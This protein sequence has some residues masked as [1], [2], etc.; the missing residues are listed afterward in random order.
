MTRGHYFNNRAVWLGL[1]SVLLSSAASDITSS[2]HL[3]CDS[4]EFDSIWSKGT[5]RVWDRLIRRAIRAMRF[6]C[7]HCQ[8]EGGG[9][10]RA[11]KQYNKIPVTLI[12]HWKKTA[13]SLIKFVNE[14]GTKDVT[15]QKKIA[16]QWLTLHFLVFGLDI[17]FTSSIRVAITEVVEW[18]CVTRGQRTTQGDC[19]VYEDSEPSAKPW[20]YLCNKI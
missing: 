8:R 3:H 6:W 19:T 2:I 17:C 20:S 18:H 9:E 16:K 7:D 10:W 5:L 13:G 4:Y 12:N 14:M 11:G 1:F 15:D